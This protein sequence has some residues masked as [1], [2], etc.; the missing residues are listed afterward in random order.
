MLGTSLLMIGLGLGRVL[1]VYFNVPFPEAVIYSYYLIMAI[2][3]LL[4]I[5]DLIEKKPVV[6]YSITFV[7]MVLVYLAWLFREDYLWQSIGGKFA[8]IFY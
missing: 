7:L 8:A 5:S 4:L 3:L 1:I 2:A 6:P